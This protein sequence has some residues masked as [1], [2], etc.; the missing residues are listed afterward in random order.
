MSETRILVVD[1]EEIARQNLVH[2]LK[3]EGWHVDAAAD[4]EQATACLGKQ[5]YQ[6]VLTDIRMPGMDGLALLR[7]IKAQAAD[8]EVIVI[9]AHASAGSAV[10]A[11]R[12]GAF[13]YVEKPFRIAEVRKIVH[14]A[15][16]KVRL[17]SEVLALKQE[18]AKTTMSRRIIA[19]SEAM[20]RLLDTARRVAPTDCTVLIHGETGTG[21]ELI[22]RYLHDCSDRSASPFVAINCGV[23]SEE[24]LANELFGHER[25]AFTGAAGVKTGLLEAAEGGT[26]FLDEVTEMPPAIQVKLLRVLQE[27]EFFRLGSTQ[28]IKIN[29]R[30]LA[31]T[32]RN[33]EESVA[34][35][36]LRSDLYFR[37]NVVALSIPPLRD[38]KEDIPVLA[39]H[40]IATHAQRMGKALPSLSPQA[41]SVLMAYDYPGNIRELENI[42]ERAIA[43]CSTQ[44]IEQDL[45][46][47]NLFEQASPSPIDSA[48]GGFQT[49]EQLEKEHIQK[50]LLHCNG[51]KFQAA[52][53]LGIDR[54]SLW[55]KL[56]SFDE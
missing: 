14:E 54:V 15:L 7:Q 44:L 18:L 21:K 8:T 51:N 16:E 37:L 30:I 24:L 19:S 35:G 40:L 22:A 55:R 31:A 29:L 25:G 47:A 17:K 5:T 45:L 11:M 10:E 13:F 12:A 39:S 28:A 50:A 46:P 2:V 4:G 43:L 56:K 53:M 32:N 26:L 38:R 49:L 1:D 3:R 42:I 52:K 27:R 34:A 41:L 23:L 33:P 48:S 9:T 6:L 36:I 20:Q